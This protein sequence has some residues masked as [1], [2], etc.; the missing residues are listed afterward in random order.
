MNFSEFYNNQSQEAEIINEDLISTLTAKLGTSIANIF[1]KRKKINIATEYMKFFQPVSKEKYASA[2]DQLSKFYLSGTTPKGAL[3]KKKITV[4]DIRVGSITSPIF[5]ALFSGGIGQVMVGAAGKT[6]GTTGYEKFVLKKIPDAANPIEEKD[7]YKSKVHQMDISVYLLSNGGKVS[8]WN[9]PKTGTDSDSTSYDAN[10]RVYAV[11]SDAAGVKAF[12]S[13]FGM[14]WQNWLV[15][16]QVAKEKIDTEK[17]KEGKEAKAT[18]TKEAREKT[19]VETVELNLNLYNKI[20][21]LITKD[22]KDAFNKM[23]EKTEKIQTS[24]DSTIEAG[25]NYLFKEPHGWMSL[26]KTKEGKY[27]AAF[28]DSKVR[29]KFNNLN[30]ELQIPSGEKVVTPENIQ[31]RDFYIGEN[32]ENI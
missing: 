9:I 7:L 12:E 2:L 13:M 6:K 15:S 23:I 14:S 10:N 20:I 1:R 5:G 18:E 16:T 19:W 30:F 17:E 28:T 22:L 29:E 8:L 27:K 31:F 3:N 21:K 32:N 25:N 24:E 26:Y 11:G 4:K